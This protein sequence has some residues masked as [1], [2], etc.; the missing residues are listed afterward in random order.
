MSDNRDD[1]KPLRIRRH[2]RKPLRASIRTLPLKGRN[3][4]DDRGVTAETRESCLDLPRVYFIDK[5]RNDAR[6]VDWNIHPA[7]ISQRLIPDALPTD[8][9]VTH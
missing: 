8:W 4:L 6:D 2:C 7:T 9:G 5:G 3:V 1:S